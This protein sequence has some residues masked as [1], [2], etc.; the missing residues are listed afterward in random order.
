MW[1]P[2]FG[3][4]SSTWPCCESTS[5]VYKWSSE[6]SGLLHRETCLETKQNKKTRDFCYVFF[7]L[8][9]CEPHAYKCLRSRRGHWNSWN[10]SETGN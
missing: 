8:S 3:T 1:S 10:W 6:Q 2:P 9:V 5:L 7:C 4:S